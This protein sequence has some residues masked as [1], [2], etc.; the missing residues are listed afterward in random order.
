MWIGILI[1]CGMGLYPPWTDTL[2]VNGYRFEMPGKYGWLFSHPGLRRFN[3][4]LYDLRSGA[5]LYQTGIHLDLARLGIQWLGVGL[6]SLG[7]I[8]SLN[9]NVR[10]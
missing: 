8:I 1:I 4:V 9:K 7:L 6:I 5:W 2:D 10:P 3:M